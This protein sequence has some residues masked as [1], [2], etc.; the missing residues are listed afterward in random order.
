MQSDRAP[1]VSVI[2]PTYNR[3]AL[4]CEAV[5]SALAQTYRDFEILVVDDGSTDATPAVV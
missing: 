3:A 2:I 1:R 4:L 5:D